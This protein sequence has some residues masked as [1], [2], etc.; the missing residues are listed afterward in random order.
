[1]AP[2]FDQSSEWNL[3]AALFIGI[4]FG[5]ILERAGFSSS[6]RIAGVFYGY[7]FVVIK[8]FF[9]AAITAALVLLLL[10]YFGIFNFENVWM[11]TT[12]ILPTI[13]GGVIMGFGFIL[14]GFCPGTS[15]AAMAIG[16]ID[17]LVF[18]IG[19]II[20]ILFYS[21]TYESIWEPI[22]NMTKIGKVKIGDLMGVSEGVAVLIFIVFGLFS[23]WLVDKIKKVY[24]I[25][26]VEY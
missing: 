7:D 2:I 10:N 1:M 19:I 25:K 15:V 13:I 11:P 23:F 9:T 5:W 12:Y 20:G 18:G 17:A 14:G 21:F 24:N 22:R 8:V 4:A 6:R 3:L 26:D 16:K